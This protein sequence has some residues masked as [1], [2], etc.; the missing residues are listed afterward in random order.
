LIR[1]TSWA[2]EN[3]VQQASS[4]S[5]RVSKLISVPN[6]AKVVVE[7]VSRYVRVMRAGGGMVAPSN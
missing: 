1:L 4:Y 7:S 2:A 5:A 6:K 3:F